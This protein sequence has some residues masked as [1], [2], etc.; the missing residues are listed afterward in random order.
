MIF[1]WATARFRGE[2]LW[3]AII[4][5]KSRLKVA[6]SKLCVCAHEVWTGVFN[7]FVSSTKAFVTS[8]KCVRPR[9]QSVHL[10]HNQGSF[11]IWKVVWKTPN[12]EQN[13]GKKFLQT[14]FQ[15]RMDL[16]QGENQGRD[17]RTQEDYPTSIV[18]FCR[19]RVYSL[20][21]FFHFRLVFVLFFRSIPN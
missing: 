8:A 6:G 15:L 12:K 4:S 20:L 21:V 2:Y 13:V 19:C 3:V 7:V 16:K 1:I 10:Q 14:S 17:E 11:F 18:Y 9:L 5:D